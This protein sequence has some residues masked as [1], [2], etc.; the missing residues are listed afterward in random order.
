[1]YNSKQIAAVMLNDIVGHDDVSEQGIHIALKKKETYKKISQA[2]VA[3][4]FGKVFNGIETGSI[5]L[6]DSSIDAVNCAVSIQKYINQNADFQLRVGIHTG[7]VEIN[8]GEPKG[9]AVSFASLVTHQAPPGGIC[10]SENVYKSVNRK[11]G[12]SFEPIY[13]NGKKKEI[14][15][16]LYQILSDGIVSN[17]DGRPITLR[18]YF[19]ALVAMISIVIGAILS[20]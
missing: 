17:E 3:Q 13:L 8:Q 15:H 1:M 2:L 5:C 9:D 12:L 20:F 19:V 11:E 16:D 14:E 6:F 7:D 18:W 10:I 4:H